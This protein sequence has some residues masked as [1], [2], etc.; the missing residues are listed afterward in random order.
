MKCKVIFA[1]MSPADVDGEQSGCSPS[2]N[3]ISVLN[4]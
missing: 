2:K 1:G 3:P 4:Y